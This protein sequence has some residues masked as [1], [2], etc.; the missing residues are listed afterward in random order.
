MVLIT[1]VLDGNNYNCWKRDMLRALNSKNKLGFI[2]GTIESPLEKTDPD[3]YKTWTRVNDLVQQWITNAVSQD[4]AESLTYY[5]SAQEVWED[6][7]ERFSRGNVSRIFEIQRDIACHNQTNAIC[8]GFDEL[9]FYYE[10]SHSSQGNQQR[11][12]QFVMGL[13]D[14][15]S[16]IR[17]QILLMNPLPTVRQAYVVITQEE[18]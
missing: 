8:N 4:I 18:K 14:T 5:S 11:L 9:T 15:Y 1:K 13:N 10:V 6:L 17:S 3:Y 7:H 12:M 2:N 16:V